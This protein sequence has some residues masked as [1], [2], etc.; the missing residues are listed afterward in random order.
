MNTRRKNIIARLA[1]ILEDCD[2]ED[3]EA[4]YS[5][6]AEALN[7][8]LLLEEASHAKYVRESSNYR[9]DQAHRDKY[10][11]YAT[12]SVKCQQVIQE[13]GIQL[14]DN[15]PLDDVLETLADLTEKNPATSKQSKVSEL[16]NKQAASVSAAKLA[17]KS[18]QRAWLPDFTPPSKPGASNRPEDYE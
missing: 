6:V 14:E 3:R 8:V 5:D 17:K 9:R 12:D 10:A 11:K 18:T 15:A 4:T 1:S 13:A 2:P 7:E 16:L